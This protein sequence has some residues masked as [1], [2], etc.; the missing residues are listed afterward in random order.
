MLRNN[1]SRALQGSRTNAP[2]WKRLAEGTGTSEVCVA[3]THR[4][5]HWH[6]Q[7]RFRQLQFC[8]TAVQQK[9]NYAIWKHLN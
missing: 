7:T 4:A 8:T 2:G 3:Q 6:A 9:D 5:P 1:H